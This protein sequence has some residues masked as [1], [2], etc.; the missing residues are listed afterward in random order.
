MIRRALALAAALA[1]AS[2][3]AADPAVTREFKV[4][5][6]ADIT[7]DADG[8][9]ATVTAGTTYRYAW[10]RAGNEKTMTL[11]ELS[12]KTKVADREL[13]D[14]TMS[15]AGMFGTQNGKKLD[16]KFDDSPEPLQKM[17]RDTFDAPI[18][19]LEVDD[20]GRVVKRTVLAGPG[21][22]TALDTGMIA[23]TTLFHPP[24]P[25]DKDEWTADGVVSAGQGEAKG[26]LT[27]TKVAGGKGGQAVKVSGTLK[28]DGVNAGGATIKEGKYVVTGTQTY[29]PKA[30]EWITGELAIDLSFVLDQKDKPVAAKGQMKL[31]FE[32]LPPKK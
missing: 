19:K 3:T 28:A 6:K 2:A 21:A 31:T 9:S 11:H 18:G 1:A 14:V 7:M 23:N 27:Y 5:A 16:A 12:L 32:M 8:T 24:Y 13:M 25:A 29:D 15:R 30:R 4:T 22:K 10:A 17:L 26:K 20:T